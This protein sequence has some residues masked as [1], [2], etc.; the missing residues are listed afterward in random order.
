M[1]RTGEIKNQNFGVF[2]IYGG[3]SS[4][5]QIKSKIKFDSCDIKDF[6]FSNLFLA[7]VSNCTFRDYL[8]NLVKSDNLYLH[9]NIFEQR[10]AG[11]FFDTIKYFY[12][13]SNNYNGGLFID[14]D[15]VFNEI[16]FESDTINDL[17]LSDFYK[18]YYGG[19]TYAGAMKEKPNLGKSGNLLFL[20]CKFF[21]DFTFQMI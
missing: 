1:E 9:N 15:K 12:S 5:F 8:S 4:D 6:S 7:S 17:N 18:I 13:H 14:L 16:K 20:N 19:T 21:Y 3:D 11:F 2:D 10:G